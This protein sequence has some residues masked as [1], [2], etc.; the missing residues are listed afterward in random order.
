M[1]RLAFTG[2]EAVGNADGG[3]E[4]ENLLGT[5]WMDGRE[6]DGPGSEAEAWFNGGLVVSTESWGRPKGGGPS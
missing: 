4:T 5:G 6:T 1:Y 3:L 2:V